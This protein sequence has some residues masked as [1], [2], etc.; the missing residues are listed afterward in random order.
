MRAIDINEPVRYVPKAERKLDEDEQTTFIVKLISAV[1]QAE[2]Q[3]DLYQVDGGGK[4]RRE[5]LATG[6]KNLETLRG[7]LIGW[8]NFLDKEGKPVEFNPKKMNAM[9]NMVP[10]DVQ[11]E[12]VDVISQQAEVSEGEGK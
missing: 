6:T 4:E 9:I 10:V 11:S 5:R 12:L 7:H 2:L 3:D 8:E 1:R